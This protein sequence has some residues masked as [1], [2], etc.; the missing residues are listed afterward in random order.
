MEIRYAMVGLYGT[1]SYI[2]TEKDHVWIIDPGD[3]DGALPDWLREQS[4]VPERIIVTH[5]HLDHF[6]DASVLAEEYDIPIV[7]PEGEL[8]YLK[9]YSVDRDEREESLKERFL[10]ALEKHGEF[11]KDGGELYLEDAP[12]RVITIGGHTA[13][14]MCLYVPSEKSVFVGDQLFAGSIGRTDLYQNDEAGLVEGIRQK[15]FVLPEE[16]IVFPGHGRPTTIGREKA[17]NPFFM[18]REAW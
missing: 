1:N 4:I 14:G 11:V 5:G 6:A 18:E 10:R 16:T 15:L 9:Q 2:L 3:G 17:G 7:F 8:E 13:C 12:M